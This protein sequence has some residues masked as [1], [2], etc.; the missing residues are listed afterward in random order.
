MSKDKK[1]RKSHLIDALE[2]G[3]IEIIKLILDEIDLEYL[4]Q[5]VLITCIDTDNIYLI[6]LLVDKGLKVTNEHLHY[7]LVTESSF[8]LFKFLMSCYENNRA[9]NE[10]ESESCSGS[11]SE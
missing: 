4:D 8:E 6:N 11:C 2:K 5:K 9:E 3:N 10:S 7:A 1:V